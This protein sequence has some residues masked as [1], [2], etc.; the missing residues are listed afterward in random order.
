VISIFVTWGV[1][2]AVARLGAG[3]GQWF[4]LMAGGNDHNFFGHSHPRSAGTACFTSSWIAWDPEPMKCYLSMRRGGAA[5]DSLSA[6]LFSCP[7]NVHVLQRSWKNLVFRV[8][9]GH[10]DFLHFLASTSIK[11]ATGAQNPMGKSPIIRSQVI[12]CTHR[13]VNGKKIVPIG[14]NGF[15][16][17]N[18]EPIPVYPQTQK[19]FN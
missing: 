11:M 10:V 2:W 16:Y 9:I 4:N 6:C 12:F 18:N 1:T 17:E 5:R 8:F 19:Y 13:Y 3:W 7:W 14:Y 15:R